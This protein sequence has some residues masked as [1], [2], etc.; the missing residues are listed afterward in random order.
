MFTYLE[1]ASPL[2]RLNPSMKLLAMSV[3]A[4]GAT[5]TFDPFIPAMLALALWLTAWLLGRVPLRQMLRWSL[6]LVSLPIPLMIFTALYTDLSRYPQPHILWQ[7][8][9]WTLAVEGLWTA[10]GL[11]LRVTTFLATSLLFIATTD[12]T[13]FAMSLAQNLK[14]PYRFAYGLLVALRFLPLL[15]REFDII[16]MA[17]RI[18]G[19]EEERGV[20]GWLRRTRRYAVPLLASAIR[21]SERTALAMDAKAFGAYPDRTYYREMPIR[22]RDVLFVVAWTGYTA[23][24]YALALSLDLARLEWIP[25]AFFPGAC[26]AAFLSTIQKIASLMAVLG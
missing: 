25:Q 11:G 4:L 8:G 5:F 22:G 1:T 9:P 10:L 15:R 2:H 6:P 21:K 7:W 17:H 18:R 24:M 20:R 19:V 13:D 12:P 26:K 16:R 23:L 3:V 14:V